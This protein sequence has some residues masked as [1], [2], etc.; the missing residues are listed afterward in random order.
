[1]AFGQN[2]TQLLGNPPWTLMSFEIRPLAVP[3]QVGP[4]ESQR[5]AVALWT[6]S[7]GSEAGYD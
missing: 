5:Q 4:I 6:P 2:S 3:S 7:R 1:M